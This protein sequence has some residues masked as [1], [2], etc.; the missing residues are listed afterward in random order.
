MRLVVAGVV[1]D[2]EGRVL[3]A[4]RT[5]PAALAGCWEF[6]GGKVEPGERPRDAL[7]RELVEELG[8]AVCV[9]AEVVAPGG[10]WPIDERHRMRVWACRAT[11]GGVTPG[12][13][14]DEVRW[15][16]L[17]ELSSL[18]WAPADVP[19]VA[20]LRDRIP[21][22]PVVI[23]N[24]VADRAPTVR[25]LVER[26]AD[27]H[28]WPPVRWMETTPDDFGP[29]QARRAIEVGADLVVVAGGDGTVRAVAEQLRGTHVEVG[30]VPLGTANIF[31]R[32]LGLSPR[33]VECAVAVALGGRARALDVGVCR[34]STA[35]DPAT[36]TEQAFLVV[37]GM[38]HDAATVAATSRRLKDRIGWAA[39]F[40]SGA[41]RLVARPFRVVVDDGVGRTVRVWSILVGNAGTIPPGIR[42]FPEARLDDGWLRVLEAHIDRPWHWLPA[43]AAGLRGRTGTRWLAHSRV[44]T[45][46]LLPEVPQPLQ[47][48][49]DV[50]GPVVSA[51]LSVD[52][53]ALWVRTPST[54]RTDHE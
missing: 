49:G 31:A 51:Q 7:A 24:P 12:I 41:A 54:G 53:R 3:C 26:H 17:D 15:L 44:R 50:F 27:D 4:R 43:A 39:Y 32:N 48:D 23:L 18:R 10:S 25:S 8:L 47:L 21:R 30:V 29:G 19:V 33:H 14:H 6:P 40:A 37:A 46:R 42:V 22:R 20:A 35:D 45:V 36:V 16:R 34:F 1:V 28:G 2:V 52:D 38:G 13:A 5:G 11:G 9:G